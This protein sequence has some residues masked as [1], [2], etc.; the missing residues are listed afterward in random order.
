MLLLSYVVDISLAYSSSASKGV[1]HIKA[2]L[3]AKYRITSLGPAHLFPGIV[4]TS[5]SADSHTVNLEQSVFIA[6]VLKRFRIEN[7]SAPQPHGCACEARSSRGTQGMGSWPCRI[8]SHRWLVDVHSTCYKARNL[9]CS[10]S[11][12]HVQLTPACKPPRG[13]QTNAT[14]SQVESSPTLH[15]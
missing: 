10:L 9:L 7:A 8:S 13:G 5:E 15:Q 1:V 3:A 12:K 14:V 2:K 4:I 11:I 6:S